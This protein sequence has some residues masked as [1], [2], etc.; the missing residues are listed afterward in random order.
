MT[1]KAQIIAT[2]GTGLV[3]IVVTIALGNGLSDDIRA[4][5][6]GM[7][8]DQAIVKAA[9]DKNFAQLAA[10]RSDQAALESPKTE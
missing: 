2:I 3:V 10:Q 1:N 8:T 7:R 6:S 5:R 9:A 4:T